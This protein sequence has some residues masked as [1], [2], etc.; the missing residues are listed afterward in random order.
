MYDRE[1]ARRR[2]TFVQTFLFVAAHAVAPALLLYWAGSEAWL[3]PYVITEVCSLVLIAVSLGLR[4]IVLDLVTPKARALL[5]AA[6]DTDS[7]GGGN[8]TAAIL[9]RSIKRRGLRFVGA[10]VALAVAVFGLWLLRQ[11]PGPVWEQVFLV[12]LTPLAAAFLAGLSGL[13][14]R[15][16]ARRSRSVYPGDA[17][18][19]GLLNLAYWSSRTV[20]NDV[21]NQPRARQRMLDECEQLARE[22]EREFLAL[23]GVALRCDAATRAWAR[24][25]S[26]KLAGCVRQLKRRLLV[27]AGPADHEAFLCDMTALL[28]AL[29]EGRSDAFDGAATEAPR[30]KARRTRRALA[31]ALP[32]AVLVAAALLLPQIPGL[33]EERDALNALRGTLFVSAFLASLNNISPSLS[34]STSRIQSVVDKLGGGRA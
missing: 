23:D 26:A 2:K 33:S 18:M 11:D 3:V 1:I 6:A 12:V 22:A 16:P 20:A 4:S 15:A 17:T 9:L 27:A 31:I 25:Q 34:G 24:G 14:D 8:G 28:D 13:R 32:G 7:D 19:I 30:E 10:A 29:I 21:W 5:W